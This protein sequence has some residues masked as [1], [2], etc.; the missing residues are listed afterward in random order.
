M[1]KYTI[2]KFKPEHAN[3]ILSFGEV[4]NYSKEYDTKDLVCEDSWTGFYLGQ[5]IACGGIQRMWEG[6]AEVWIIIQH[7]KNRHKFFMLKNIKNKL[8][9]T[10]K[11]RNYK[12][13]QSTVRA[14]FEEGIKFAEWFGMTS[15]GLMKH[16]GPDGKDYIRLARIE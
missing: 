14:D 12:R 16:Y 6:V 4:E 7:G 5:P 2:E 1:D 8:E 13:V 11:L 10:I 3:Y 9:E 15:E